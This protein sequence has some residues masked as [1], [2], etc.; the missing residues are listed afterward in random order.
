MKSKLLSYEQKN[1]GDI[2][3]IEALQTI[4]NLSEYDKSMIQQYQ[5]EIKDGALKIILNLDLQS[6]G[7]IQLLN[8]NQLI[9]E[10]CKNVIPKLE[11]TTIKRLYLI[12]CRIQSVKE[13]QLEYLEALR[14][15]NISKVEESKTLVKEIV[16]FQKLKKLYLHKWK[17][18]ISPLSQM[19]ELTELSLVKCELRCTKV[20][21]PLVHLLELSLSGNE[22]ID[23]QTVQYLTNITKLEL[24]SC[25][26][27]SVDI[28]RPLTSLEQL[29]IQWNSIVHLQPLM[30]LSQLQTLDARNNKIINSE[31]IQQH[32]NFYQ[33]DLKNQK[34]PTKEEL[35][36][37]NIMRDINNPVISLKLIQKE[38]SHVKHQNIIFRQKI[39]QKLQYLQISHERFLTQVALL[40][41]K[42]NTFEDCQ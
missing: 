5:S 21:K 7:F 42:M 10:G 38:S 39:T 14:I 27:V 29:D 18:D 15:Y 40:F 37:A 19:T 23:I 4:D 33:F 24:S 26:L 41:L 36:T 2:N 6:L 1:S 11:N 8:I 31:G 25:K 30:E 34:L 12:Q 28:L 22:E 9:L 32:P 17:I 35:E 3:Q 16:R 13:F 20:L